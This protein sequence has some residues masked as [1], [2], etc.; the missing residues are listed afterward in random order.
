[1]DTFLHPPRWPE[2][3]PPGR[4]ASRVRIAGE[5]RPGVVAL[6]GLPDDHG[7]ILNHGRAGA[8]LGPDA[9]RAALARYAV[10]APP[11]FDW[12]DV[13]DL[14][15]VTPAPGSGPQALHDTHDRV[16]S[17]VERALALGALPVAIGGGHDLTFASARALARRGPCAGVAFDAHLDVRPEPG[18]GMP[19]RALAESGAVSELHVLGLDP[20]ANSA[21]H[22]RWYT[23]HA[24]T[25]HDSHTPRAR[26]LSASLGIRA[27][28]VFASLDLDV[29]DAAFAPGVS[30]TN[31]SGWT[32]ELAGAWAHA[33]GRDPNV[34]LF[35]LMELCPPH[36]ESGRTAR[37][38]AWLFLRFLSGVSA[39]D[40][41]R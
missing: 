34:A 31:P 1:M 10:S 29:I 28:T 7:V 27:R 37:L 5:P 19:F 21:E 20:L 36:D 39:R 2:S 9:F 17:V 14:G 26:T 40:A 23:S 35:D 38:A 24:G 32:P 16:T 30:A 13:L 11:G 18:S 33:S 6:I 8:R 3:I 15:D 25:I 41:A 22:T 4:F 12:P